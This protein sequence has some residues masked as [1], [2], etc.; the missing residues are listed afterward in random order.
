MH[1][2][3]RAGAEPVVFNLVEV[4]VNYIHLPQVSN[5]RQSCLVFRAAGLSR[6]LFGS[7]IVTLGRGKRYSRQVRRRMPEFE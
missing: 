7:P 1:A 6:P 3:R 4:N 5:P 2:E